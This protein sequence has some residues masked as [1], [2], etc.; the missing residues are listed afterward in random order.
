MPCN[1]I[2]VVT[3]ELSAADADIL[4]DALQACG[5]Q[6]HG[7]AVERIIQSGRVG[8][9]AGQEHK[10]VE[11][12]RVYAEKVIQV[13]ARRFGFQVTRRGERQLTVSRR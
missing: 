5:F 11:L 4:R 7:R 9:P 2:R 12:R 3:M 13:A 6:Y 1:A 8:I 10:V